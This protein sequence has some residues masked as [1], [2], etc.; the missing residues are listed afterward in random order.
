VLLERGVFVLCRR[1]Y[2]KER[3]LADCWEK[4]ECPTGKHALIG[5]ETPNP[6]ADTV[7][8]AAELAVGVSEA[9]K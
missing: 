1:G 3:A 2:P 8:E 9:V 5:D 7:F 6:Q 4:D